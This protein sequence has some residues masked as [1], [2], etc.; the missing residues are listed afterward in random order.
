MVIEEPKHGIF[1]TDE[2]GDKAFR[3][4]S[5]IDKVRMEAIVSYLVA[6]S[7]V[8]LPKNASKICDSGCDV[9]S[10]VT[11]CSI[12]DRKI[13]EVVGMGHKQGDLYVLDQSRDIHD[14][15]SS[16]VDLTLFWLNRS[17]SAFY[18]WHSWLGH[19][20]GS[21]LRFLA[22]IGALGKLD[23]HDISYCSGCKL[24]KYSAQPFSNSISSSTAPFD[25]VH[26][27][28]NLLHCI[29]LRHRTYYHCQSIS[30]LLDL[31]GSTELKP[32]LM[33]P[34]KDIRLVLLPKVMIKSMLDVKNASLNGDLNKEVFQKP[35]PG[36][37]HK[38][39]KVCKL[40]KA[41]YGLKQAPRACVGRIL[42]S[43]YVDDMIITRDDYVRIESLKLDLAHCFAIKD[44]GLLRYFLD[45]MVDDIP[46]DAKVKYTL[47][48]M[49]NKYDVLSKSSTEAE[50]RA[51]VV[52]T[53]EIIWLRRFNFRRTS[54]TG[55]PAQ[56]TRSSN[57]IALDSSYLLVLITETSQSRQHGKSE[58]DSNYLS[59]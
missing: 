26:Y 4:W 31:V 28:K 35:P 59:D 2:F 22:S 5:D 57:A 43:L 6:A 3:R 55:F 25:L 41:L 42:L 15:T 53:S 16:S 10:S 51:M 12:Y 20:S 30:L 56:S 29:R 45:K 32:N 44:L 52:T 46:I 13:Q 27:D 18:L 49:S 8:Q 1:F 50:Y 7:M 9:N 33:G 39:G 40:R 23:T 24:A 19:V 17:S 54:L 47:K 11:E 48:K 36:V 14:T 37:S 34:L 21:R 58:S 38:L